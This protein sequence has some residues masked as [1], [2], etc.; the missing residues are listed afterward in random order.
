MQAG[1]G[2][3]S[4]THGCGSSVTWETNTD[5]LGHLLWGLEV[6]LP[7]PTGSLDSWEPLQTPSWKV[8]STG[9]VEVQA[10]E[11]LLQTH[12]VVQP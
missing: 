9:N 8:S 11:H 7:W 1:I 10:L 6:D 12:L 2:S 5:V 4:P 3:L